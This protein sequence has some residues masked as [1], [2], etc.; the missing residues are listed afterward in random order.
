MR[1][2][3]FAFVNFLTE[4]A[5]LEFQRC[6]QLLP[7]DE[8]IGEG[9]CSTSFAEGMQGLEDAINKYRDSPIMHPDVPKKCKPVLFK[10]GQPIPF[11]APTKTLKRPKGLP[12]AGLD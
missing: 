2:S 11:P 10:H 5:A 4:N 8:C 7:E 12:R 6:F 9:G 1:C 3:H